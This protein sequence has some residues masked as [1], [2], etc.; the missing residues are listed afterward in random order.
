[1]RASPAPSQLRWTMISLAFF[2]T[3]INY[4]DRQAL[5]VAAPIL[6]IQFHLSNIDYSRI[7][8]AFMLAYTLMNGVSGLMIDR[9]G[10]RVGYA[11]FV[12]WWSVCALLHA[13]AAQGKRV[14]GLADWVPVTAPSASESFFG[15]DRS[16]DTRLG[17]LRV[18]QSTEGVGLEDTLIIAQSLQAREEGSPSLALMNHVYHRKLI[19][20][21]GSKKIFAV[22]NAQG[23]NGMIADVGYR[24]VVVI[25]DK[26]DIRTVPASRCVAPNAWVLTP[27]TFLLAS[28]FAP[29]RFINEDGLDYLR[30][31]SDDG[32]EARMVSRC[33]IG[34][35]GPSQNTVVTFT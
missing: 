29:I 30:L 16:V 2:A 10:T 5:S 12:G 33:N 7:L 32:I 3:L 18:V 28:L 4:L 21:L 35:N 34:C 23:P 31:A 25:G 13:F 6:Q 22:T 20:E 14:A 17:G 19:Q 15:V 11:L 1:M 9:L 24:G 26:G 8:F 27:D